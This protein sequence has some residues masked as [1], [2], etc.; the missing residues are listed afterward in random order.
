MAP[1][2]N[3]FDTPVLEGKMSLTLSMTITA[4][5]LRLAGEFYGTHRPRESMF[6]IARLGQRTSFR[7]QNSM[8]SLAL[9]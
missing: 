9:C 4:S 1:H 2:E 8:V 7:D 3:E 6:S 5:L